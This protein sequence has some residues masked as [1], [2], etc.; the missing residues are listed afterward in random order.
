MVARFIRTTIKAVAH[1]VICFAATLGGVCKAARALLRA[2]EGDA[3][4]ATMGTQQA[5]IVLSIAR[6]VR[7]RPPVL[8]TASQLDIS[9]SADAA[10]LTLDLTIHAS[11]ED[12]GATNARGYRKRA[13]CHCAIEPFFDRHTK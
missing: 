11:A 8:C 1:H 2:H 13:G 12:R 3:F 9:N 7:M 6:A 4:R 10:T 5:P